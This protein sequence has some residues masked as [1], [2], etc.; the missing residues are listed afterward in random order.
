MNTISNKQVKKLVVACN[1][2][3]E[4]MIKTI[5]S[6][7]LPSLGPEYSK[8]DNVV[9][10]AL[11]AYR[12][13]K[14]WHRPDPALTAQL[15]EECYSTWI[16]HEGLLW[17]FD[18]PARIYQSSPSVKSVIYRSRELLESWL[19]NLNSK[20]YKIRCDDIDFTPGET[21]VTSKGHTSVRQKL[22]SLDHWTV[23]PE[24]AD[25]AAT[26]VWNTNAL[27]KMAISH[28]NVVLPVT[29]NC[30]SLLELSE[31]WLTS[32]VKKFL[33]TYV[34]GNRAASVPKDNTK[35][36]FISIEPMF[37]MLLQR[38][39]AS[40]MRTVLSR[41]GNDVQSGQADHMKM[42]SNPLYATIDFSNASDSNH[43][44]GTKFLFPSRLFQRL[45]MF[46]SH[47]C[48]FDD[49]VVPVCKLSSMGNGFTFETMTLY[50]LSV[51]R[52]LDPTARV[53]GDDVIIHHDVANL[54]IEVCE[55]LGWVINRTKT[56]VS[57]N[58]RESCG[59]F[60]HAAVGYI[61]SY[62]L[63][64]ALTVDDVVTTTNKLFRLKHVLPEIE[65][66]WL[67]LIK[68][69]PALLKGP[70]VNE[71]LT[72][73]VQFPNFERS[74]RGCLQCRREWNGKRFRL[75]A[76]YA[77]AAWHKKPVGVGVV[78]SFKS[79]YV[80]QKS[81]V[82]YCVA[83]IGFYLYSGMRTDDTLRGKG[84]WRPE[85]VVFFEDGSYCLLRNIRRAL[86]DDLNY[87]SRSNRIRGPFYRD[88]V[89][90]PL[91]EAP[92]SV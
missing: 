85:R 1:D 15:V 83:D 11:V 48:I 70:V 25:E 81:D 16:D 33:F 89:E 41:V 64:F 27:R 80:K 52:V 78:F 87:I 42:I 51:A 69:V 23:T 82:V 39:I 73:W 30:H 28:L 67:Q 54:F 36:R 21:Y 5:S 46:R 86:L 9:E 53:Y 20:R 17:S 68:I 19:K 58:F 71:H 63:E 76:T 56:F 26:L 49:G 8:L 2:I 92:V 59:G 66:A 55:T 12:L 37:N 61:T 88:V 10:Q 43:V 47:F 40:G 14:S 13:Q 45:D 77:Q 38:C 90:T 50:L 75:L 91:I 18:I 57:G 34:R 79:V 62:K 4:K 74:K 6:R 84:R 35:R 24:A 72:P 32:L 65:R 3:V 7:Q 31:R 44:D 29:R 22:R 60:Y